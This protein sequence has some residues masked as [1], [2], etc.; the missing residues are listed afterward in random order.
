MDNAVY[1]TQKLTKLEGDIRVLDQK[2][3]DIPKILRERN[4][5]DLAEL[6]AKLEGD[7]RVLDQKIEHIPKTLREAG[8]ADLAELQVRLMKSIGA[9]EERLAKSLEKSMGDS[10]K[11]QMR[12]I[13]QIKW[14]IGI[15]L[16]VVGL[17][18]AALGVAVRLLTLAS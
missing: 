3:E 14:M 4:R 18:I 12:Q 5:A 9:S 11:R 16:T 6:Q 8:R 15:G 10:E 7:I 13:G 17:V 2:I 1:V